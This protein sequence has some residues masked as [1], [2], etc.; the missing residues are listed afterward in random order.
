MMKDLADQNEQLREAMEA[1]E[2]ECDEEDEE[3]DELAEEKRK[4]RAE[5]V[6]YEDYTFLANRIDTME[7]SVGSIVGK[8]DG[9]LKKIDKDHK[10]SEVRKNCTKSFIKIC[11]FNLLIKFKG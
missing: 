4:R 7:K 8:I 10:Q 11:F 9:V 6:M 1:I 3:E 2:A 5:G